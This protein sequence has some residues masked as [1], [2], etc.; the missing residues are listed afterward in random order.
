MRINLNFNILIGFNK[1][2]QG[3]ITAH[4]SNLF[5]CVVRNFRCLSASSVKLIASGQL[6]EESNKE[7]DL[8]GQSPVLSSGLVIGYV[9]VATDL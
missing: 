2:V 8:V 1:F 6:A 5:Y 7:S 3:V 4:K 9:Q